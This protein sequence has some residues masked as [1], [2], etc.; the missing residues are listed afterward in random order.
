MCNRDVPRMVSVAAK[1]ITDRVEP[2][3]ATDAP[4][5]AAESLRA[6]RGAR[7]HR[8]RSRGAGGGSRR[9]VPRGV[10]PGLARFAARSCAT[11]PPPGRSPPPR[12]IAPSRR[13][14]SLPR[15]ALGSP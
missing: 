9:A 6:R 11:D 12:K 15:P 13:F 5:R 4:A 7:A 10:A 2:G 14:L 8:R 3:A 1:R